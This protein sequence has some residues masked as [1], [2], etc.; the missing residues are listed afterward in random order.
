MK[1]IVIL[2]ILILVSVYI[3][4]INNLIPKQYINEIRSIARVLVHE[5]QIFKQGEGKYVEEIV[6]IELSK[7]SINKKSEV[8]ET[9]L[10]P[11]K[12]TFFHLDSFPKGAGSLVVVGKELLVM[13]RLG[14]IYHYKNNSIKRLDF[15]VPNRLNEFIVNYELSGYKGG[16]RRVGSSTL[17]AHSIVYYK[18]QKRLF[19]SHTKFIKKNITR[20]LVSSITIDDN[21]FQPIGLWRTDFE[22]ENIYSNANAMSGG[23]GLTI[24]NDSLFVSVGYSGGG[25]IKSNKLVSPAQDDK[26][27][28]GKIFKINLDSGTV[29][30]FSKG[31]RNCQGLTTTHN[32]L[33][34]GIE[35]GPQG[36]DEINLIQS[37]KNYGWPIATYGTRYGTYDYSFSSYAVDSEL[38]LT[39]PVFSFVPSIAPSS[40][41]QISNFNNRWDGDLLI[42][43][44]KAQS[45]FRVKFNNDRVVFSEPIWIGHRVRDITIL[46]NKIILLTDDSFLIFLEVNYRVLK[47]NTKGKD[48][49][50]NEPKLSKCLA[51]HHFGNTLPLNMAPSLSNIYNRKIGSDVFSKYSEAL[52]NKKGVWTKENLISFISNPSDFV[53]GTTMPDMGVSKEEAREIIESLLRQ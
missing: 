28:F 41:Y 25:K 22:S 49:Y 50:N 5:L 13:D 34:L 21:S 37:G 2:L 29:Q 23:G 51:C 15:S 11:L 8:I 35:H 26:S 9:S 44:L 53:S 52:K 1:K 43:S 19:V 45:I 38:N 36:G 18:K 24:H 16:G 7:A 4:Y 32:N 33:I 47:T 30:Q 39:D 31:H 27:K 40:I 20:F 46:D 42:G 48:L 14:G 17:R 3:F 12:K 6:K 10:L